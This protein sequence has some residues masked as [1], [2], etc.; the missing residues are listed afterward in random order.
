MG[1]AAG[2][3]AGVDGEAPSQERRGDGLIDLT[4][5]PERAILVGVDLH[6]ETLRKKSLAART[7]AARAGRRPMVRRVS[8][9][10]V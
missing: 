8:A 5:R 1:W 10:A 3:A 7:A 2:M 9:R 4:P 6:R